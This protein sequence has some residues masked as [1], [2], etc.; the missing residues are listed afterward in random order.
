MPIYNAQTIPS[1]VGSSTKDP[2]IAEW[3]KTGPVLGSHKPH[4][5][6]DLGNSDA[7][8]DRVL[9]GRGDRNVHSRNH[10]GRT[11][12]DGRYIPA[13]FR[14]GLAARIRVKGRLDAK[15]DGAALRRAIGA[16]CRNR[17]HVAGGT[18]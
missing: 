2:E 6:N 18:R 10:F 17:H 16:L 15:S 9:A 12:S 14:G 5:T 8:V 1:A 13:R 7:M 3:L 4:L 11:S